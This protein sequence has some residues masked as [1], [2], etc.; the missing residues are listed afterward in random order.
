MKLKDFI[1]QKLSY[2]I[3]TI[4]ILISIEILLMAY[5]ID[6]I[7][8][9]YI[10][11]A[12]IV[13]LF[14]SLYLEYYKKNQFY[15]IINRN[16]EE[17]EE[18]Y[19]IAE[20]I[21]DPDFT[22]G[23]ILKDLLSETGKSMKENIN[24]YKF[25]QEEYKEYIELWIHEVKLPISVIKLIIENNRNEL[26]QSID[27][28]I[29]KVENY[30]EQALFYARSNTLE[31]DYIIKKVNLKDVVNTTIIKNKGVLIQSNVNVDIHD[32]NNIVYTDSKWIIFI[33]NQIIQ[34][35][36]KYSK[37][38]NKKIE[39]YSEVLKEKTILNIVDNGI[40]ISKSD[41]SKVFQKGFT[42]KNGRILSKKSTGIGLYLVKKL[43]N[44]LG[45]AVKAESEE[46][47][48]T[49]VKLVFPKSSYYL[50]K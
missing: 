38:E 8:S 34:N 25:S 21:D 40:G 30:I 32:I 37:D 43:C 19:L 3:G 28:E 50:E 12:P 7:I 4:A 16:M 47:K 31:K 6:I 35:C 13:V 36:I 14:I 23:K 20:T 45:I 11:I 27:E 33:L 17:L 46:G 42:G 9:T 49:I 18:K 1:A 22:E 10:F 39:I 24:K 44:K 15:N 2:I 5:K 41:I 26:T 48:Y 29:D